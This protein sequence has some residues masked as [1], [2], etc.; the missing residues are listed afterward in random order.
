L[1]WHSVVAMPSLMLPEA[2]PDEP[3]SILF[4]GLALIH[5]PSDWQAVLDAAQKGD[6]NIPL[7]KQTAGAPDH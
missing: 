5:N 1:D 7:L 4:R 3:A 6:G 2:M